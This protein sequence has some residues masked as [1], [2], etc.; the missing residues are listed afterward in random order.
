MCPRAARSHARGMVRLAVRSLVALDHRP[1]VGEGFEG[2]CV[3][4]VRATV[5]RRLAA[6]EDPGAR[7]WWAMGTLMHKPVYPH[8]AEAMDLQGDDRVLDVACGQD[9]F[10]A[11]QA[12]GVAQV[13]GRR[14]RRDQ[15]APARAHPL[16]QQ[17]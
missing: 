16:P 11:E 12:A 8:V 13:A 3:M 15:G 4:G 14:G 6:Y 10:L 1:W 17:Q 2:V 5:F 9:V 7:W